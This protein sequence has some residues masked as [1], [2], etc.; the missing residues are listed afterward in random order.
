MQ[1]E[2]VA[3][4]GDTA[5]SATESVRVPAGALRDRGG[6]TVSLASTALVGLGETARYLQDYPYECAEQKASKAL[7]LL[8]SADLGG[9]F[10]MGIAKPEQV[11]ADG[12]RLLR[13]LSGYQCGDGGFGLFPGSCYGTSSVYL[14]AYVLDVMRR[15]SALGAAV[16]SSTV[17]RALDFLT[18]GSRQA[19][20]EAQWWPA[21][22]ASH[23]YA[24]K[25]LSEAGRDRRVEVD[26]LYAVI[27]RMPVFALSYLADAMSARG[28]RGPRYAD[29]TRRITNALRIDADRAHVEE[30]D[31]AALVW[32]WNTNVRATAVVLDG[33]SRRKDDGTFVSP[34]VRWLLAARENG[35]WSTTQENVVALSALVSYY[36]TFES[37][38]PDMT[39]S[40]SLAGQAIG[41]A[42]FAGRST[43]AQHVKLTMADLVKQVSTSAADLRL[44]RTGTGRL[45]YTAR[46]QYAS[47]IPSAAVV[48]RGI[49][50]DRRYQKITADGP[51][52][53][54]T[55]FANGDLIRVTLTVSLPHEGRFL[56]FTDPLPAGFEAVDGTLK[57]T[58]S[59]L[60]AA[61]T[62]QSSGADGWAWWR[63]GGFEHV[64]KHDDRVMAFATRL[65]AGRHELTYLAR[66]TT[67]GTFTAPG[68]SG[69][70][71]YAPEI[72]GRSATATIVIR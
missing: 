45:F 61:S 3:A 50:I 34:M 35:R 68:A 25:V 6:L 36:K 30:V 18:Y 48:N 53:A 20:V 13:D 39:A 2:T 72:V 5:A 41:G 46:L 1:L 66:A 60:A 64:E 27:D 9:T 54:A 37:D 8:L 15:A 62:T 12:I 38:T 17:E 31:D 63:R 59:D 7:A 33:I 44:S 40:V 52:A 22:A 29:V 32:L 23:A 67:T 42:K 16:E 69:E 65:S 28:E 56:A 21:W 51:E 11:R 47:M 24:Q 4:Y 10:G 19:P 71:M 58:A 70:A 43:T 26:R 49:R 14:T 55:S 57:V